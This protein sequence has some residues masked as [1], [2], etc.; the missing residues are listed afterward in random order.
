[1]NKELIAAL[2]ELEKEKGIKLDTIIDALNVA[3]NSAYKKNYKIDFD[4]RVE[5][6]TETGEIKVFKVLTEDEKSDNDADEL[7][8]T[9]DNFGRIAAQTA[10]QVIKQRIKEAEREIMYE[11]FKDRVGDLVTG[12]IQQSD[13]RFTLVDLGKVE[14]LLPQHEQVANERYRHGE[15]IKAFISEVRKTTKGPQVIVSRTHTGL[16]ERLFELEVP[17]IGEDIVEIVNIARE[18][19]YRTKIAVKSNDKNVDP[20]GAC[21]GPKG[22]RVRMVVDELSGEKIDIVCYSQDVVE[23]IKNSLSPAKV[24]KVLTEEER[25]F[26]LVV[27]PNDQLSLAIGREGQNARLAAKLTGWKIDIKSQRQF[28]EELEEARRERLKIRQQSEEQPE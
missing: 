4:S 14:A 26:A 10:M 9:P 1:M 16:I 17:E 7:E 27:V 25:K 23:F 6:D 13:A 3:L 24:N 11:E 28:D 5:V 20:V 12:I 21:V 19:G 8:V 15:R 18:P 2:R 22:S